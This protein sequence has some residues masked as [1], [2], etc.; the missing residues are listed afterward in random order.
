[1]AGA[2]DRCVRSSGV[3]EAGGGAGDLSCSRPTNYSTGARMHHRKPG[4]LLYA[5]SVPGRWCV[6]GCQQS[7]R[8]RLMAG[9]A[10]A[11]ALSGALG[12]G[13]G[14]L[15]R[16]FVQLGGGGTA[17]NCQSPK[18][19]PCAEPSAVVLAHC[20]TMGLVRGWPATA[21]DPA[22]CTRPQRGGNSGNSGHRHLDVDA[23]LPLG[24]AP[25]QRHGE[26]GEDHFRCASEP[27]HRHVGDD[28][29]KTGAAS[30]LAPP[31]PDR[32]NPLVVGALSQRPTE[33][34]PRGIAIKRGQPGGRHRELP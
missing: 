10:A 22:S 19:A 34:A 2:T 8:V 16:P 29:V 32:H 4:V 30:Q 28:R 15:V 18:C 11:D 33:R 9:R 31:Q 20:R 3:I 23:A 14:R 7:S 25:L 24:C 6:L 17:C 26:L 12:P 27:R 5:A 1:M 21:Q 13:H